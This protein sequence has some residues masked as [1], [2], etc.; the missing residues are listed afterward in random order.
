MS[1][2]AHPGIVVMSAASRGD[3][4]RRRDQARRNASVTGGDRVTAATWFAPG[5]RKW[6]GPRGA[7][8]LRAGPDQEPHPAPHVG[9]LAEA[10]AGGAGEVRDPGHDGHD[11]GR[12]QRLVEARQRVAGTR[13]EDDQPGQVEPD[14]GQ[15]RGVHLA[16][17]V[18]DDRRPAG[19]LGLEAGRHA[20][21]DGEPAVTLVGEEL[22]DR[23]RL[24]PSPREPSIERRP[25]WADV[26]PGQERAGAPEPR[27][28]LPPDDA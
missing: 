15:G 7:A 16:P 3:R 24:D 27:G 4:L 20:E 10:V 9:R 5:T 11:G 17:R 19:R 22:E 8:G 6:I 13:P 23:P 18:D 14:L 1:D 2:G 12:A 21:R 26:G 25:R 28:I